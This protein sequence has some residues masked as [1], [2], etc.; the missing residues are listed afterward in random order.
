MSYF[1]TLIWRKI[2]SLIIGKEIIG[3]C[4]F[5]KQYIFTHNFFQN[6]KIS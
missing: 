5:P 4:F 1:F 2:H 3:F 6:I